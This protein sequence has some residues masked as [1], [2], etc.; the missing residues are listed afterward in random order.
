MELQV[1]DNIWTRTLG[2]VRHYGVYVGRRGPNGEDVV[3]NSK[4]RGGVVLDH[5]AAFSGGP[6]RG[7]L[8][9]E[10]LVPSAR[11]TT[12]STS[13]VSTWSTWSTRA[14]RAVRSSGRQEPRRRCS[15]P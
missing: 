6:G 10:D 13:T 12:C 8:L 2:V 15:R 1:G 9:D 3:H 14:T 7:T 11:A 5:L 4:I